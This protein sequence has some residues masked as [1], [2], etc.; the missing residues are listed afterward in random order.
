MKRSK[1]TYVAGG[2]LLLCLLLGGASAAG[3]IANALLQIIALVLILWV[4]WR[5][6]EPADGRA[7]KALLLLLAAA[8][9]LGLLSLV[10]LPPSLWRSLPGREPTAYGF[11]LMGMAEPWLP[12]SLARD[13]T[14][15]S[16]LSLLPPLAIF[17]MCLRLQPTGAARWPGSCSALRPFRSSCRP[18]S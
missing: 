17:L 12:L 13:R 6:S 7:G 9:L 1:T 14:V 11:A 8:I 15:A 18:F 4:M 16:L 3:V 2:Y 10:P 5:R